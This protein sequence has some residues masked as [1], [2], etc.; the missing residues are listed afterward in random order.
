MNRPNFRHLP[1]SRRSAAL[2]DPAFGVLVTDERDRIRI[3]RMYRWA[4][5]SGSGPGVARAV[6][7][8]GLFVGTRSQVTR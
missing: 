5:E 6:V 4:R 7:V 3:R 2:F 8:T 1:A